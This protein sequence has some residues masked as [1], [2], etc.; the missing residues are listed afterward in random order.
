MFVKVIG[1]LVFLDGLVSF[2]DFW[3]VR[4]HKRWRLHQFG[5]LLRCVGGVVL[6]L[7]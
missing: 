3:K 2:V 6:V 1:V 7:L 5:R 4:G